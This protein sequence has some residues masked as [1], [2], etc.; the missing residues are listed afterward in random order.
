MRRKLNTHLGMY[1]GYSEHGML[2]DVLNRAYIV[3]NVFDI[4]LSSSRI[5]FPLNHPIIQWTI[6]KPVETHRTSVIL[7]HLKFPNFKSSADET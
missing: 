2:G 6:L 5:T 7:G 3:S 1:V 4:Y